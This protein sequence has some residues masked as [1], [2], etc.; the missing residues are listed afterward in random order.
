MLSLTSDPGKRQQ[1]RYPLSNRAGLFLR[2]GFWLLAFLRSLK[3]SH[4]E[5]GTQRSSH[6]IDPGVISP[7][8]NSAGGYYQDDRL[9]SSDYRRSA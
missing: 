5:A 2:S 6:A 1:V 8:D 3:L 9:S 4:R 7:F